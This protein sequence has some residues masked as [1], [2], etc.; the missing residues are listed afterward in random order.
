[1]D[2][3]RTQECLIKFSVT[4]DDLKLLEAPKTALSAP[5]LRSSTAAVCY[6][7]DSSEAEL[8]HQSHYC[9][10][11]VPSPS[12]SMETLVITQSLCVSQEK[13]RKTQSLSRK[14]GLW[15]REPARRSPRSSDWGRRSHP[16]TS[17]RHLQ[18]KTCPPVVRPLPSGS[19]F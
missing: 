10:L 4:D 1:M 2:L 17:R 15:G 18:R 6:L 7:D 11:L 14:L 12:H 8:H 16:Q 5:S 13:Q 9:S 3:R 19:A